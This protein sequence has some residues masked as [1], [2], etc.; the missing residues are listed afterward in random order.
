MLILWNTKVWVDWL[1]SFPFVAI[2]ISNSIIYE[3]YATLSIK[4]IY[5]LCIALINLIKYIIIIIKIQF[6]LKNLIF[7]LIL[8]TKYNW[9]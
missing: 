9:I 1:D 4:R 7:I 8:L 2:S 3:K 5:I 6:N